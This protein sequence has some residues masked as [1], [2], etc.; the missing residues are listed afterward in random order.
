MGLC[1]RACMH[2]CLG[3]SVCVWQCVFAWMCACVS[4][5]QIFVSHF[6]P[7]VTEDDAG[8]LELESY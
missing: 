8:I 4:A 3:G 6:I 5:T 2:T 1:V 7:D